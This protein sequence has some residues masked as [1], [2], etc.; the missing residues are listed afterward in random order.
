[1]EVKANLN[2]YA[3]YEDQSPVYRIWINDNLYTERTFWPDCLIEFIQE[4]MF[5]ELNHGKHIITLEKIT[6]PT[7]KIWAEKLVIKYGM[8]ENTF[9]FPI[10]PQDKQIIKFIIE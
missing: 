4:E 2:V 9:T 5:F 6:E 3:Y 8:Q 7:A 10:N 1:M